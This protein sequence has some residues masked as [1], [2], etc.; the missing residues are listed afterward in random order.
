[1]LLSFGKTSSAHFPTS[2]YL[3]SEGFIVVT[4]SVG[5]RR[6][7]MV[8]L[9]SPGTKRSV[10]AVGEAKVGDAKECEAVVVFG[11]LAEL[12]SSHVTFRCQPV[13]CLAF[14]YREDAF[15]GHLP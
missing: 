4:A 15:Q 6:A 5:P 10:L 14:A 1:M 8:V 13:H 3:P 7:E 9:R 2:V 12:R 11:S